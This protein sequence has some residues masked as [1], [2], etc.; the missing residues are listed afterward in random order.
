MSDFTFSI[1]GTFAAGLQVTALNGAV[2]A[3]PLAELPAVL[4][5]EAGRWLFQQLFPPPVLESYQECQP[6]SLL[7]YLPSELLDWP[8]Q[9]MRDEAGVRIAMRHP[10]I[11]L[12]A[13]CQ[14]SPLQGPEVK[15][16]PLRILLTTALDEAHAPLGAAIEQTLEQLKQRYQGEV[17]VTCV[18]VKKSHQRL[19]EIFQKALEP[20]HLWHHVGPCDPGPALRLDNASLGV[21]N[22]NYLLQNQAAPGCFLLSTWGDVPAVSALSQL[23]VPFLLC[24]ADSTLESINPWLWQGFYERLL[25]HDDLAVV[26]A[27]AQLDIYL[28]T[29]TWPSLTVLAQTPRLELRLPALVWSSRKLKQQGQMKLLF[30][31]AHPQ[32]T[33]PI[34]IDREFQELHAITR[35]YRHV[36]LGVDGGAVRF[37]DMSR[38]LLSHRPAILH[39]SGHG[40]RGGELILEKHASLKDLREGRQLAAGLET[41]G[42]YVAFATIVDL[43]AAYCDILRCVVF[44][45]CYTEPLA[46]ALSAHIDCVIGMRGLINDG[47]A[48]RFTELFY[49][50]LVSGDSVGRAFARTVTEL[51]VRNPHVKAENFQL[52]HRAGIDPDDCI[53]VS[54]EG[55][56]R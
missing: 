23:R 37:E 35:E 6:D 2:V 26:A 10:V 36:V 14:Q 45:A 9:Q 39:F 16:W 49:R 46:E 50:G 17:V 22:L 19:Q 43:L 25:T 3:L 55:D 32:K 7:L 8:W 56:A 34:R 13:A 5:D 24:Q 40:T 1:T 29:C 51:V 47:L 52:K 54:I 4:P 53:Y 27:L 28:L 21:L 33:A 12:P 20:F 38:H 15:H 42:D 44:N 41:E 18:N 48:L 11:L 30:V 31:K